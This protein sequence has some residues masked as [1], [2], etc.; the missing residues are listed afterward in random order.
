MKRRYAAVLAAALTALSACSNNNPSGTEREK[1]DNAAVMSYI[2][3][4]ES[5]F[6]DGDLENAIETLEEGYNET[7]DKKIKELLSEYR[8][9]LDE[10][11]L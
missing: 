7:A 3:R 10:G 5:Y 4:A 9:K 1:T 8:Q 2:E 6:N 11:Y